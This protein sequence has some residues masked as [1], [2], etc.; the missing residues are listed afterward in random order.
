MAWLRSW[1]HWLWHVRIRRDITEDQ[2]ADTL[3]TVFDDMWKAIGI[4]ESEDPRMRQARM[5]F[6]SDHP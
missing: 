5:A 6:R 4:L 3:S 2:Y 1:V